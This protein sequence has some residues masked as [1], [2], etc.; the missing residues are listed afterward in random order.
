MLSTKPVETTSENVTDRL[1]DGSRDLHSFNSGNPRRSSNESVDDSLRNGSSAV[2]SDNGIECADGEEA[3]GIDVGGIV[4]SGSENNS[5]IYPM[6]ERESDIYSL[7]SEG[8]PDDDEDD[9]LRGDGSK[10]V[11]CTSCAV[12]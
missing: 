3:S 6:H 4:L 5:D 8:I 12:M 7:A 1:S 10:P 2:G 11:G 9:E